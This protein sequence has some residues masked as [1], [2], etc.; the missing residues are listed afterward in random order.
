LLPP[1]VPVTIRALVGYQF[2]VN[3]LILG[4]NLLPAFPLDG[5]RALRAMLWRRTGS[6]QRATEVAARVGRGFGYGLVALGAL[7]LL[8]SYAY[9]G[10][11]LAFIGLFIIM[12][13]GQ[14]AMGAEIRA[15]FSGERADELMTQPVVSIPAGLRL[16][17][18]VNEYFGR[19]PYTAFPVV[20]ADGRAVGLI[21][22]DRLTAGG[23]SGISAE[24]APS[25]PRVADIADADPALLV[26]EDTD[27]AALLER[28]AFSRTGRAVVAGAD[29]RPV[30]LISI[31]DVQRAIRS[32]R[33]RA[34]QSQRRAVG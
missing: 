23:R 15:V 17:L 8:G 31:T 16:D 30:G 3:A 33:L 9:N 10:L 14:Q 32:A 19:Y 24:V 25:A 20:D 28:P 18:A 27:V 4:F 26:S 1:S 34:G 7:L 29:G 6:M 13:A 2:L 5:G 12:A 22:I 11:W 21:T